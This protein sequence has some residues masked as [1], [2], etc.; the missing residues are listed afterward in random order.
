ME[1]GYIT[2]FNCYAG[3]VEHQRQ[4]NFYKVNFVS[5]SVPLAN[6]YNGR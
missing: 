4:P 2:V 6:S 5:R 1:L 3:T